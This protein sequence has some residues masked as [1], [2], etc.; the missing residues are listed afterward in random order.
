MVKVNRHSHSLSEQF[1][2]GCYQELFKENPDNE[3]NESSHT[4]SNIHV[5][6]L[7]SQ[8]IPK[9]DMEEVSRAFSHTNQDNT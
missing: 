8:D 5:Y 2:K 7:N 1:I 3:E 9:E 4:Y 6:V